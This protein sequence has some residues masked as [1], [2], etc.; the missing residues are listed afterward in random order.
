MPVHAVQQSTIIA[1][2][3]KSEQVKASQHTQNNLPTSP[4]QTPATATAKRLPSTT[5]QA[6]AIS[7]IARPPSTAPGKESKTHSIGI[8]KQSSIATKDKDKTVYPDENNE[9][10]LNLKPA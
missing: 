5:S 8:S 4:S 1:V 6:P 2:E 9:Q 3:G 7:T 10:K